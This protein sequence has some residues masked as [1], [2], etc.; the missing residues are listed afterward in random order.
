VFA[1]CVAVCGLLVA[2]AATAAS[3]PFAPLAPTVK[4]SQ[5]DRDRLNQRQI[6]VKILPAQDR[7]LAVVAA[8]AL[9]TDSDSLLSSVRRIA[10]LKRGRFVPQIHRISARPSVED[11]RELTLDD[12]DRREIAKCRPDDCDLKLT[13]DEM[14]RLQAAGAGVDE[15][16]RRML[17]HRAE[18]YLAE[19][20]QMG[21]REFTALLQHSPYL[22]QHLPELAGHLARYPASPAQGA[23]SFLYWS[24]EVYAWKPMITLTHVTM[25]RGDGRPSWPDVVIAARDIFS[26]RYTS[27]SLTLTLLLHDGADPSRRYLVY[28]NR[29]WVDG[30]RA[31]WRP[32]V[33]YRIK[34]QAK[35]VFAAVRDRIE[36]AGTETAAAR[37]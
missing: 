3:D 21:D 34:S 8:A 36:R 33:E 25:M 18:R 4:L 10:D 5:D 13:S 2:A 30:V 19:G 24:K 16:F 7:E 31:L 32:F 1:R 29:T 37:R 28:L 35:S 26:T 20:Q 14:T 23:E 11:F 22:H 6:V 12:V 9:N 17:L 27:A 15:E